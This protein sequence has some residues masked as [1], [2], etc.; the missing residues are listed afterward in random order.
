MRLIPEYAPVQK[1]YLCFC[2]QFFNTRFGYGKTQCEI[3]NIASHFVDVELWVGNSELPYLREECARYSFDL[4]QVS[5]NPDTP[6]RSIIAEYVPIFAQGE[7]GQVI[8][9]IFRNPFLDNAA[10][11]KAFSKR[12]TH[13][14][15][16]TW[17][18]MGFDFA[19]AMLLVNEDVVL[20]SESL[21]Q[22][23][24]RET[25][26]KFFTDHFPGQSFYIVPPL[27]G[28]T[29]NDLDMYLWPIA[30]KAWVVSEYPAHTPQAESIAPAL[31]TLKEHQHILHRVPG[32]EPVIYDDIN[33]MPNYA[34]G[35]ILNR[36]AFVP[37][38]QRKEDE[39]V[40][41]ILRDYGYEVFPID[42]SNIILSNSGIHCISKTAPLP[43]R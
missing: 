35:V 13:R 31:Q 17:M 21:F 30:P 1:F 37:A 26:L 15:G 22:G 7:D 16:F 34:N 38:Y 28:D 18:E 10:D 32:L 4:D 36:A 43:S 39:I 8:S 6:G 42:C 11:L 12:L 33:T 5:L 41:G 20:L 25:R 27:A 29:T 9:L 19:T 23:A 2:H 24:E 14:L 3:M 40:A